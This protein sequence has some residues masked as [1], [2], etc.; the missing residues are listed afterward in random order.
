M[1]KESAF[2]SNLIFQA[3]NLVYV[4]CFSRQYVFSWLHIYICFLQK[5]LVQYQ[6]VGAMLMWVSLCAVPQLFSQ[7]LLESVGCRIWKEERMARSSISTAIVLICRLSN[8]ELL[9]TQ[10]F[11]SADNHNFLFSFTLTKCGAIGYCQ[12]LHAWC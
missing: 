5:F 3:W 8:F 2:A 1:Y 9:M 11:V 10:W 4:I 6:M 12:V 7:V